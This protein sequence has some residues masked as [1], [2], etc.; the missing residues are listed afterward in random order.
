MDAQTILF[1]DPA[2]WARSDYLRPVVK[3]EFGARSDT[4]PSAEPRITPYVAE[5]LPDVSGDC[6]FTV[7]AVAPER[8]F[9][10]KVALRHEK[11]IAP[12]ARGR[13]HARRATTTMC[14]PSRGRSRRRARCRA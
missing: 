7:R 3:I 14:G 13:T 6:A 2:V 10:E 12:A 11:P 8:T 5:A 1:S 9:C 4:E